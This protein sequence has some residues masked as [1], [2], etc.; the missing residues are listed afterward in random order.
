MNATD[1]IANGLVLIVGGVWV[2][3]ARLP[4]PVVPPYA[5]VLGLVYLCAGMWMAGR[6]VTAARE[7]GERR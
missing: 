7:A 6:L 2:E 5:F 4:F 3:A 1:L